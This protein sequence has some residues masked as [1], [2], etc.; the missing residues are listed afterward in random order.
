M[1]YPSTHWTTLHAVDA[2]PLRR[3]AAWESLAR[4]YRGVI[5]GH[6]TR[7]FG[8]QDADDH[9]QEFLLRSVRDDWWQR[10]DPARGRF[11]GFLRLLLDRYVG[12]VREQRRLPLADAGA[13]EAPDP[14]A[15]PEASYDRDFAAALAARALARVGADYARRGQAATF[16]VLQPLLVEAPSGALKDAAEP[17]GVTPNA[18]AAA[19]RRLR[20]AHAAAM[21][22][23][24]ALLLSDPS[25]LDEEWREIGAAL[26]AAHA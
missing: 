13:A 6:F 16:A 18:L 2:D 23:E 9:V 24:L 19:L 26:G 25:D 5:R 3:R 4:R 11:R 14:A 1:E 10:A 15:G 7:A 17:L 12:H 20:V 21:R 22:T 8:A